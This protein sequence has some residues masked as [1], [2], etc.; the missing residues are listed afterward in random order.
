[1]SCNIHK[2]YL[3]IICRQGKFYEYSPEG[4]YREPL[5]EKILPEFLQDL[6]LTHMATGSLG[7]KGASV[8]CYSFQDDEGKDKVLV[9]RDNHVHFPVHTDEV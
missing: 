4:C 7:Y 9:L 3:W 8:D 1:M 6:P 2:T 5:E